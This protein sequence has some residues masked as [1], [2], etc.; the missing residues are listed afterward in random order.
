ML[1]PK[2]F[3]KN[4]SHYL[5]E[6][7]PDNFYYLKSLPSDRVQWT[8]KGKTENM[9]VAGIPFFVCALELLGGTSKVLKESEREELLGLEGSFKKKPWDFEIELPFNIGITAERVALN[10][11]SHCSSIASFTYQYVEKASL[12]NI[13]ILDTRKT[14][15][16]LRSIQKYS[17]RVGGAKNHRMAQ[18]DVWMIK[19]NHKVFFGGLEK[20]VSFFNSVGTHYNSL[21]VEIHDLKELRHGIELGIRN[22]MLDNFS[23][24]D[25]KKAL[26]LK[27]NEHRFEVSGGITLETIDRYLISGVDAISVGKLTYAA[28]PIDFSLKTKGSIK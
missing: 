2:F 9:K 14:L 23:L 12:E 24:E 17:T 1:N 27:K 3:E 13:E 25:I 11:L 28:P 18:D 10:L 5:E 21:V 15:P 26:D 20:A 6:D 4:I 8:L 22:F 7:L 16:G 19:D